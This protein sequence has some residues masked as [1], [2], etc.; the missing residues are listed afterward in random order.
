MNVAGTE[1]LTGDI[2]AQ[3]PS[4]LIV[5]YRRFGPDGHQA[6]AVAGPAT[7]AKLG[8][9]VTIRSQ[10]SPTKSSTKVLES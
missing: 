4:A 10:Q 9:P 8:L 6:A 7:T 1:P 5:Q 3:R 2:R